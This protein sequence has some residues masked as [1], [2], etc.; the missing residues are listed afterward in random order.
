[1]A[2]WR[3]RKLARGLALLAVWG[4]VVPD[5]RAQTPPG[6]HAASITRVAVDPAGRILATASEDKTVRTWQLDTGQPLHLIKAPEGPGA[7]GQV[8]ALAIS[9]DGKTM[10][11]AGLTGPKNRRLVDGRVYFDYEVYL[12]ELASGRRL[13]TLDAPA[14]IDHLAYSPA[15]DYLL[16]SS[17]EMPV[18]HFAE[19]NPPL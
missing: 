2:G 16:A 10:A 13:K 9:P 8:H 12:H 3:L 5:L 6:F 7:H 19:V 4:A 14:L 18:F 17:S 11:F 1:M 15:G